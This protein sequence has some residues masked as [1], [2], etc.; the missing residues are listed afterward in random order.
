MI[1]N[2]K[3]KLLD[4]IIT[5]VKKKKEL[6]FLDDSFIKEHYL[7]LLKSD[8]RFK[9]LEELPLE[10]I[11]KKQVY[12]QLI[13]EIRKI[14]HN[15]YGVFIDKNAAKRLKLLEKLKH[16]LKNKTKNTAAAKQKIKELHIQ[17]LKTHISSRERLKFYP[18]MYRK[19]FSIAGKPNS[20]M[21]LA[22]GLNP[23]SLKLSEIKLQN[24]IAIELNK[25]DCKFLN[26]YFKTINIK[27]KAI[28]LDLTRE[29]TKLTRFKTDLCLMLK[30]LDSLGKD[31]RK[32]APKIIQSINSSYIV[33]SFSIKTLSG[34]RMRN[35]SRVWFEKM[36]EQHNWKFQSF[37]IFNELFYIINK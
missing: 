21:D 28:A 24:Y 36:C 17:L 8:K 31:K 27:G 19:I 6:K 23:V 32:L 2:I 3:M 13:K 26:E 5:D 30:T 14:A 15:V 22:S 35:I 16:E 12:K 33:V 34:K 7:K 37:T 25:D 18:E 10:R 4:K 29:Y 11:E 1:N 20:I 9:G